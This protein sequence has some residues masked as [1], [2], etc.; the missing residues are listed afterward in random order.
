M[1]LSN[2]SA[3][4]GEEMAEIEDADRERLTELVAYLIKT[5]GFRGQET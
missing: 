3:H 1:N 4:A 5:Y 2:H